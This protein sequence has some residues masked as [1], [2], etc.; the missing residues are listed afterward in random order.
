CDNPRCR[1]RG[2]QRPTLAQRSRLMT[3]I[4]PKPTDVYAIPLSILN[5]KT[6]Q[7]GPIPAGEVF[8]ATSSSSAIGA[9]ITEALDGSPQLIVYPLTL[10]SANTMGIKVEVTVSTGDVAV[11]LTVDY[12]MPAAPGDITLGSP[13]LGSQPAPTAP[14][15]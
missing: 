9:S 8:T 12:A 10:P 14:G 7:I 3:T 5:S 11:D 2:R 4:T 15:P 13:V 6:G 1:P